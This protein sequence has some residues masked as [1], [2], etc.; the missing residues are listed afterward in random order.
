MRDIDNEL[1]TGVPASD[2]FFDHVPSQGE[3]GSLIAVTV[4][5]NL[6]LALRPGARRPLAHHGDATTERRSH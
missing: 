3:I 6:A 2:D 4:A 1:H 5:A